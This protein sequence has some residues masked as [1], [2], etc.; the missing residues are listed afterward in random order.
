[1]GDCV[2]T[3]TSWATLRELLV[4]KYE[5]FRK[6]LT[7]R[8]GSDDL[9][10]ELLHETY[11]HLSR[12]DQPAPIRRP[13]SYLFRIALNVAAGQRRSEPREA[14]RLEIEAAIGVV[15]EAA[16]T[17]R[18]VAARFDLAVLERAIEDLP[19]RRRSIFLAARVQEQPIQAI[20]DSLGISRRLV[21]LELKQA[22]IF[23]AA[24]LERPVTQRFGP[25]RPAAS[26]TVKGD[27]EAEEG[28]S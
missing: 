5:D 12:A 19:Q 24:R 14:T 26:Y 3:E 6:R 9:A 25:K 18:A 21:E 15:D 2:M 22:L 1:M 20:A 23:C 7:R 27:C 13:E 16:Q 10:K 8:L 11:L 4:I 17:E 28:L